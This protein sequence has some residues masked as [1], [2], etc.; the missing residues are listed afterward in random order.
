MTASES[1]SELA[2]DL[3]SKQRRGNQIKLLILWLVP[4]GLMAIAGITYYLVQTGQMEV[5][6]KSNGDLIRP[7]V[8]LTELFE[9]QGNSDLANVWNDKWTLVVRTSE[10]CEEGCKQA[11][12]TSRQLHISLNQQADRVQRILLIDNFQ[13]DADL[14]S[15][16]EKEHHLLKVFVTDESALTGLDNAVASAIGSTR[17]PLASG[18]SPIVQFFLVDPAGWAMMVYHHGHEGK[19]VLRDLKHLLRYSRER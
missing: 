19:G 11:L 2:P 6:S 5:G 7:P 14:M 18:E 10:R 1:N 8:Q 4:V 3:T 16:I 9:A 15:F 12:Y 17:T 13:D